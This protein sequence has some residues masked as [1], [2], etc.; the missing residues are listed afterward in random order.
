MTLSGPKT[1]KILV[2]RLLNQHNVDLNLCGV[3]THQPLEELI[4]RLRLGELELVTTDNDRKLE[5]RQGTIIVRVLHK[6]PDLTFQ[7]IFRRITIFPDNSSLQSYTPGLVG[8]DN[9]KREKCEIARQIVFDNLGQS[10]PR[11]ATI[12]PGAFIP[13]PKRDEVIVTERSSIWYGI[14]VVTRVTHFDLILPE[15]FYKKE[16]IKRVRTITGKIH[17]TT[18]FDW[19]TVAEM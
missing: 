8:I 18:Y 13:K 17:K 6:L 11:L 2:T 16:Y 12:R 3:G 19:R 4:S 5:I 15:K 9:H 14:K 7:E 1:D 10:V